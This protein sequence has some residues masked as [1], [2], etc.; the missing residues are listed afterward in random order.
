VV[1]AGTPEEVAATPGSHTGA[2]LAAVL[3]IR[4]RSEAVVQ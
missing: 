1:A 4:P 2:A 3:G